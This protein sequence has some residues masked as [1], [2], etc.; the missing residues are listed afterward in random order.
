MSTVS[1]PPAQPVRRQDERETIMND[2]QKPAA[3]GKPKT[4]LKRRLLITGV[5]LAIVVI[6]LTAYL[7]GG[8]YVSTDDAY[9]RQNLLTVST[10]V[11][12]TVKE[13]AVHNNQ[14]V[15]AGQLLYRLDDETYQL[16]QSEA[17]A[18]LSLIRNNVEAMRA[19]YRQKMA[20]VQQSS[21][22]ADYY[23]KE[24][25][26]VSPL[27]ASNAATP[28]QVDSALRSLASAKQRTQG[29]TQEAASIL[30]G[31]EGKLNLPVEEYPPYRQAVSRLERARRDVAHTRVVASAAGI[32][33]QVDNL[34]PGLY[35][36]AAQPGLMLVESDEIWVE[37]N[38]KETDLTHVLPQQTVRVKVDAYPDRLWQGT[39]AD[40]SPATGAQFSLLPAQNSSG[41]WVKVVQRIPV[42]ISL[43]NEAGAPQLRSGM[44]VTVRIDT[45]NRH[46]IMD[47]LRSFGGWFG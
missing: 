8:R 4:S 11:A 32:V 24:Y 34:R 22:D 41:N 12:G 46:S 21:T 44:S 10:D 40:V 6:G 16:A 39:V 2:V 33:A 30:A 29:L 13:V 18:Q 14:V 36:T 9:V 23:Q 3:P 47:L 26:R 1:T 25:D 27:V 17:E 31:L 43:T 38:L 5:P 15:A 45:T 19:T 28:S 35:L 7:L 37:A 42:R 20:E